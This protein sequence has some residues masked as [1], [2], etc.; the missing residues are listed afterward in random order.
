MITRD[1]A[2]VLR[3]DDRH[4]TLGV[5][6]KC[7]ADPRVIVR[8]RALPGWTWNFGHPHVIPALLGFVL[9]ALGPAGFLAAQRIL[10]P[11]VL[12]PVVTVCVLLLVGIA[13]NIASGPR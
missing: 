2:E 1:E 3:A 7:Q 9:I 13:H 4:W 6:Y 11:T 5:L 12:V 10:E 8:H